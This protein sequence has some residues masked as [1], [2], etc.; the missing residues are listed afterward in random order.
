[1]VEQ[2][3]GIQIASLEEIAFNNGWIDLETLQ[4]AARRYGKSSYGKYLHNVAAGRVQN[5]SNI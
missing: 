3:Q 5:R 2:N 4:D 1:M